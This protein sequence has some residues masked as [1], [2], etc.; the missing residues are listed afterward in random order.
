MPPVRVSTV[1]TRYRILNTLTAPEFLANE[2]PG[3]EGILKHG[4]YH[5][6][7]GLGRGRERDVGRLLL[8]GSG[9]QGVGS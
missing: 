2:T 9:C 4:M 1:N 7:R 5:E 6:R 3:W 8:P